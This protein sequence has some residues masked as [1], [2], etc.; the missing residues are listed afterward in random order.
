MFGNEELI[1]RMGLDS[2]KLATDL[3]IAQRQIEQA[4][5]AAN[6]RAF[7]G[8]QSG[9]IEAGSAG[10]A[11]HGV[12]EKITDASPAAG[13]AL[14][15]AID[16]VVGALSLAG[17]G[18]SF[19]IKKF[20]EA[21]KAAAESA[22]AIAKSLELTGGGPDRRRTVA[23][24]LADRQRAITSRDA[25]SE[26]QFESA[27]D[28]ARAKMIARRQLDEADEEVMNE[29]RL[30]WIEA[31][32]QAIKKREE[33]LT[34][35][36]KKEAEAETASTEA[37]EEL[38]KMG[39][40]WNDSERQNMQK[41]IDDYDKLRFANARLTEE[42][43]KRKIALDAAT[44]ADKDAL[45]RQEQAAKA[46][47]NAT[48]QEAE[49]K[50]KEPTYDNSGPGIGSEPGNKWVGDQSGRNWV[51]GPLSDTELRDPDSLGAL[52]MRTGGYALRRVL[53]NENLAANGGIKLRP[54]GG[55]LDWL[56]QVNPQKAIDPAAQMKEM[57][58]ALKTLLAIEKSTGLHIL[59]Q[60]GK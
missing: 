47:Q 10:R 35:S 48:K 17:L 42:I 41:L 6:N 24:T 26:P 43:I 23:N 60:M 45:A 4:S 15:L 21:K 52:D 12:L 27:T 29:K 3:R 16:P 37:K 1:I 2:S 36:R 28:A 58:D 20:D 53:G 46:F 14:K 7:H 8:L 44:Q 55:S 18:V 5:D 13:V 51:S 40:V 56:S 39:S 30:R 31:E 54:F 57:A 50:K 32:K 25:G 33:E 22:A 11:F 38:F 49:L 59:P 9:F 34:E 19:L